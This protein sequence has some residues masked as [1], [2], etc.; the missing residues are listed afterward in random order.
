ME[1]DR[2][3]TTP[4]VA[5][6][7]SG[8]SGCYLAQSLRKAWPESE[9]TVF[10]QLASPFGLVRYGVAA[11]HQNTKAVTRQFDRLFERENV[12][13]AGNIRVGR[14]VTL[15]ELKAAYSVIAFATGLTKDRP[16]GIE[17][18]NLAGVIGA[19]VI[20]R[21]LNSHPSP[22]DA[23]LTFGEN[24]T[25]IGN[26]NVAMDILRFL[27]KHPDDYEA[28]DINDELVNEYNSARA[29]RIDVVGRSLVADAKCDALM[30]RELGKI[31]GV[32]FSTDADLTEPAEADRAVAGRIAAV[33]ELIELAA[34]GEI[35]TEVV[36]H[37][38]WT[39]ARVT[40]T[41]RVEGLEF[42]GTTDGTK[43]LTLAADSVIAAIGFELHEDA[44]D[45]FGGASIN[46]TA[47]PSTGRFGDDLYRTGWFKRGPRG[48]IPENRT[49]A[50]NVADEIVA[51]FDAG[52]IHIAATQTGFSA[53]P[54]RTR[55]LALSFVDWQR[56]DAHE[57]AEAPAGRVRRK[58][59]DHDTM[60]SI[61]RG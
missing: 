43:T 18:D 50:K 53:L 61:A 38:G 26:G 23:P 59:A 24:V 48:T 32:R 12:Q 30:L 37:F 4:S 2:V 42:V 15:D 54:E 20:T 11:D 6:I 45:M 19:G 55:N 47:D 17:G 35:E 29:K 28:S 40:G 25:V 3:S 27:L 31:R 39:P 22:E 60:V 34:E 56:L 57:Q 5:I 13:F 7:G 58:L 8:P 51:D 46:L 16:L 49:D 10:D 41:D 9:I 33:R 21:R 1:E 44:P 36:F 52:K 14:D